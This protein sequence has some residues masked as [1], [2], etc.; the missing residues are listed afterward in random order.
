MQHTGYGLSIITFTIKFMKKDD[1]FNENIFEPKMQ[2]SQFF[3]I[4]KTYI[5]EYIPTIPNL[6]WETTQYWTI[7]TNLLS[8]YPTNNWQAL[9]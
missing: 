1:I 8:R 3:A 7:G 6:P 2:I 5:L 9:K 4:S